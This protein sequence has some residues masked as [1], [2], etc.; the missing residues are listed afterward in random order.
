MMDITIKYSLQGLL[1]ETPGSVFSP[2]CFLLF[3]NEVF[4][5]LLFFLLVLLLYDYI[6]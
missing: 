2:P 3:I 5:I 1:A 4:L 6:Q